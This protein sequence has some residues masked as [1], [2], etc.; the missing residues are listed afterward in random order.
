[1][2]KIADNEGIKLTATY[3]NSL[4]VGLF[5]AGGFIPYFA[6]FQRLG[7]FLNWLL[8][9]Y[10]GRS[11]IDGIE[12]WKAILATIGMLLAFGFAKHL[13]NA[14]RKEITKIED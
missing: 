8:L 11:T 4:S 13:R 9:W 6:F 12:M 1:M 10:Q 5:V 14:A 7:E 3:Y 2:G